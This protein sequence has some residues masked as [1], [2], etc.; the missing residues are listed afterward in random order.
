LA[1]EDMETSIEVRSRLDAPLID[2]VPSFKI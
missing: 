1:E 2:Q